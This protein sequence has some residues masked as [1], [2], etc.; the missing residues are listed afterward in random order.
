MVGGGV[1]V[2]QGSNYTT[3]DFM[4]AEELEVIKKEKN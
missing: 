2:L 3:R 4:V 1:G